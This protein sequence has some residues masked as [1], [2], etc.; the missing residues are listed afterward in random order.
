ME[1]QSDYPQRGRNEVLEGIIQWAQ[2]H[3][4]LI[5]GGVLGG[6]L[7]ILFHWL[8]FWDTLVL[9]LLVTLGV[10]IGKYLDERKEV[11]QVLDRLFTSEQ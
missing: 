8:G 7:G 11:G 1:V 4:R 9:L 2:R 5:I 10:I 6:I 3:P